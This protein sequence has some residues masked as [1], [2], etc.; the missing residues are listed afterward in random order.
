M[1]LVDELAETAIAAREKQAGWLPK[2]PGAAALNLAGLVG[3]AATG[4][5]GAHAGAAEGSKG[6]AAI[7]GGLGG[8]LVGAA[9]GRNAGN[10]YHS[11]KGTL[12]YLAVALGLLGSG[13]PYMP[14]KQLA[15]SLTTD[16]Q[17]DDL[18]GIRDEFE[19][20]AMKERV[21]RRHAQRLDELA[22]QRASKE[23]QSAGGY[24][25][26]LAKRLMPVPHTMGE[27][28]VRVPGMLGGAIAGHELGKSFEPLAAEGL[29]RVF[30]PTNAKELEPL[31]K[32][33][34]ALGAPASKV[35]DFL[36][37][38]IV[39]PGEDLAS[40]LRRPLPFTKPKGLRKELGGLVGEGNIGKLQKAIGNLVRQ[41]RSAKKIVPAMSKYRVGG[42]RGGALLGG[43]ALGVPFAAR[44][45]WQKHQGGEAAVRARNQAK[46]TSEQADTESRHRED[47]LNKLPPTKTAS[48][49]A[50]L[51]GLG[52]IM[53]TPGS[54]APGLQN[55]MR[56]I[57]KGTT[58]GGMP[59][60]LPDLNNA[61][62]MAATKEAGAIGSIQAALE[63]K[64]PVGEMLRRGLSG[65]AGGAVVGGTR[66]LLAGTPQKTGYDKLREVLKQA[67]LGGVTG[68][69]GGVALGAVGSS[70]GTPKQ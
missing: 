54:E 62:K 43:A 63:A 35:K 12:K 59:R 67:L 22:A 48:D 42:A 20:S 64:G 39:T 61:E 4:A 11:E 66:E 34:T 69:L 21:L 8:G 9:T 36:G 70:L 51:G 10:L 52:R 2:G 19:G 1:G 38:N 58:L 33:F 28:A 50:A 45:L 17:A 65:G 16:K 46:H 18:T 49:S 57:N 7:L 37:K 30:S 41:Q 53:T 5:M 13:A 15:K 47:I 32:R 27:A 31:T 24:A 6:K 23:D 25:E 14:A 3:G 60:R 26:T 68:G 40:A 56:S 44:A 55:I 29:E